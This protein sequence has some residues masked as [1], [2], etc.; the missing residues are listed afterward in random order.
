MANGA[1]LYGPGQSRFARYL[2]RRE[3]ERPDSVA[4]ELRRGLLSS[5]RGRVLELGCGEGRAFELYPPTVEHVLAV[6]PD[7]T[8]A[9]AA[10]ERAATLA[11]PIE[12]VEGVA[13]PLPA[14]DGSVDAVVAIWVLCSV[15]D[16]AAALAELRRVLVPGGE[17]R[18]YEHVRS[19]HAGFRALQHAVDRLFWTRS[20]GGCRTT[21]D[22]AAAIRAAGFEIVALER[23]FHSSSPLTVTAAPYVLGTARRS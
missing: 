16:A 10:R 7:P 1:R 4:Q 14:D 13:V 2:E 20:L 21:R 12:V 9:A 22:T 19:R 6:E 18:F 23:G 8:A 17:L 3:L 5:L 11:V 15:P